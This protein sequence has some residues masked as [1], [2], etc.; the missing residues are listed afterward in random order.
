[1]GHRAWLRAVVIGLSLVA[2]VPVAA[3][4]GGLHCFAGRDQAGAPAEIR[5][6]IERAGRIATIHGVIASPTVGVM[7]L[8]AD[9]AS[10]A[11]RAFY[12]HEYERGAVVIRFTD[13]DPAGFVL[14]VVDH[15]RYPFRRTGC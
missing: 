9:Y 5:L 8:K 10:G 6:R 1:M 12:R 4:P 13:V 14:E 3:Q 11:G 2:P 7:R 15:G